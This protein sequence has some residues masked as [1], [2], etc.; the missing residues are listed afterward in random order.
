M[1]N[2]KTVIGSA[3]ATLLFV[4]SGAL[5]LEAGGKV[6]DSDG[7]KSLFK[8]LH[9][10][11]V[12][13]K[14]A[15]TVSWLPTDGKPKIALLCIHGFSLHKGC[16]AAFGKEMAKDGIATYAIDLRGFG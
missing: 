14:N 11:T 2:R 9:A 12:A 1:L 3:I 7:S 4:N 5:A 15:P 13:A 8:E 16:Y 10:P 6:P